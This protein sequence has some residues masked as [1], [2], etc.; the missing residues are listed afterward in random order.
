[1][2][3]GKYL[4]VIFICVGGWLLAGCGACRREPVQEEFSRLTIFGARDTLLPGE[5]AMRTVAVAVQEISVPAAA[6]LPEKV[7]LLADSLSALRFNGLEIEVLEITQDPVYGLVLKV[8]LAE[9]TAF[10]GPGSLP[11]YRSWY[12]FFQGSA[13]GME[14]SIILRAT[15]LQ[16]GIDGEWIDAVEFYYNGNPIREGDWDHLILHGIIK[17]QDTNGL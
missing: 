15:F 12:D 6:E 5:I 16:P 14:T 13:G 17:P 8:N 11:P 2:K 9:D 4:V 7:K 1:M 10:S 3:R